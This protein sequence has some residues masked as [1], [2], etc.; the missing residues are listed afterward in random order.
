MTPERKHFQTPPCLN[1]FLDVEAT[2]NGI[3]FDPLPESI[4]AS[5]GTRRNDGSRERRVQRH[6]R[7][8]S[9][10][11]RIREMLAVR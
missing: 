9:V 4:S 10:G 6:P 5:Q 1:L 2:E 3:D 7:R 11:N 8:R